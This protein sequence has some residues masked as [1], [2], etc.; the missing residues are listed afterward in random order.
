MHRTGA[1]IW[2][3]F[4]LALGVWWLLGELDVV[5]FSWGYVGPLALI[6]AGIGMIAGWMR[7]RSWH[8]EREG[9]QGPS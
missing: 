2:G 4:V 8:G 7:W 6:A 3:V 1:P 5:P 9:P